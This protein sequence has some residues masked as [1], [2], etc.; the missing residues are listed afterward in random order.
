MWVGDWWGE[1]VESGAEM[2]VCGEGGLRTAL[3]QFPDS[4]KFNNPLSTTFFHFSYQSPPN[5]PP[6]STISNHSP[7]LFHINL[8]TYSLTP[9]HVLLP[10]LF[11]HR[12]FIFTIN[13]H[14]AYTHAHTRIG[15]YYGFPFLI[16]TYTHM[17]IYNITII[18][19]QLLDFNNSE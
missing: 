17:H 14:N 4:K 16:I 1:V 7:P 18:R 19:I 5:S 2:E 12:F 11:P 8:N 13:A 6:F 10:H 9:F 15:G 3:S